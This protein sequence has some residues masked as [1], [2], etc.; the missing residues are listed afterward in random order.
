MSFRSKGRSGFTLIELLVVIAIIAILAAILFPVFAKAREKARQASCTSNMKQIGIA[1]LGYTQDYDEKFPP[2]YGIGI[3]N[4]SQ[5]ILNWGQPYY[6]D[7][8]NNQVPSE[9]GDWIKNANVFNCPSGN[10]PIG[11][12][13][14]S[15]R[16]S[17]EL[18]YMYNDFVAGNSQAGFAATT[19]TVLASEAAGALNSFAASDGPT[20]AGELSGA[21]TFASEPNYSGN[22]YACSGTDLIMNVGHAIDTN[23][24]DA[25]P[26]SRLSP[27]APSYLNLTGD[28]QQDW[29][30]VT[31]HSGG[32]DFLL[33]DGHVKWFRVNIVPAAGG[34]LV[35]ST[36]YFPAMSESASASNQSG[37]GSPLANEPQ[38]GGNMLGYTATFQL[39]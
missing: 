24:V 20:A 19:Q 37:N 36:V 1:L 23:T 30:D 2:L 28:D 15:V 8:G 22:L 16:S 32:G 21:D 11:G 18:E 9:L 4:G 26:N 29:P 34:V 12:V 3:V 38:P 5:Y 14:G 17:S 39:N 6:D 33:A 7:N 27:N 13:A 25:C 35:P 10:R 31:R